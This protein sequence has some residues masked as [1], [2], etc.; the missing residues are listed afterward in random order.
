M[1]DNYLED[2]ER[3][4]GLLVHEPRAGPSLFTAQPPTIRV[5]ANGTDNTQTDIVT[6]RLTGLGVDSVKILH[7]GDTQPV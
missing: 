5:P 3:G 4:S 2:F 1:Q 7:T 6:Y